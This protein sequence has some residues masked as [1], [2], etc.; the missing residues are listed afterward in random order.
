MKKQLLFLVMMM[1]PLVAS[2]HDIE[3]ANA[4]GKTIYYNYINDGTELAVTFR[5]RNYDEYENEYTGAI[6]IPEEVT[7]MSRARKVTRIGEYTFYQCSSLSSITI[8]NSVTSIGNDAFS[9]CADLTSVTI[10]N[11]V[12]SIGS[13]AFSGCSGLTSVTIG[14]SVTSI[15]DGAFSGCSV[16]TSVTLNSN[17]IASKSYSSNDGLKNIFGDQ[18][19]KYILG[20]W[21]P[22]KN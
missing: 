3:V 18:V 16:L 13:S 7:Y 19:T 5:G 15:G 2:A 12:T 9:G 4:D 6:V 11:S 22:I 17:A 14:N 20:Y 21:C 1:L 10:G 8:P